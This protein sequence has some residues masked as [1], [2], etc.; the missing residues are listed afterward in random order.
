MGRIKVFSLFF[1]YFASIPRLIA[2]QVV[3]YLETCL[4]LL[5]IY[6]KSAMSNNNLVCIFK[7]ENE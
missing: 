1:K 4:S 6:K 3:K 5:G 7:V 2:K